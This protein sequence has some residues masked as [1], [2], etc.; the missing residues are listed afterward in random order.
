MIDELYRQAL[1]GDKSSEE[2]LF[3][4]MTERFRLFV[5][6]RVGN[7]KDAED[8]VQ[9]SMIAV[10]EKYKTLELRAKF[11]SWA[12]KVLEHKTLDYF[13]VRRRREA[14][15]TSVQEQTQTG[16][17]LELDPDTKRELLVYLEQVGQANRRFAR[18]LN[19]HYHGFNSDEI[20]EK[21][22]INKNNF[23]VILSRARQMLNNCFTRKDAGDDE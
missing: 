14:R 9:N 21:L 7:D 18:I 5:R 15:M 22:T 12:Y 11:S 13:G 16:V 2:K 3:R 6:R 1:V 17:Q 19:L 4:Y 20:C 23:Y 8:I 10:A